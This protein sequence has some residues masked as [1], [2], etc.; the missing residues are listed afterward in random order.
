[1]LIFVTVAMKTHPNYEQEIHI[2]YRFI[3]LYAD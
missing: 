1:M 2:D 3:M